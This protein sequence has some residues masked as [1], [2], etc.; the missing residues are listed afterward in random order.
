MAF[1]LDKVG[2]WLAAGQGRLEVEG[3]DAIEAEGNSGAGTHREPPSQK[4]RA[5]PPSASHPPAVRCRRGR[6]R[7]PCTQPRSCWPWATS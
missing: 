3:D 4:K 6:S 1:T 2:T 5:R 7:A